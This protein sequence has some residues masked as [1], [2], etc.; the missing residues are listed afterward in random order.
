MGCTIRNYYLSAYNYI[1]SRDY[2]QNYR[3]KDY[4][5]LKTA[6]GFCGAL[7]S[8]SLARP[9]IKGSSLKG[10]N[11]TIIKLISGNPYSAAATPKARKNH[12]SRRLG[13]SKIDDK[14]LSIIANEIIRVRYKRN[15][16]VKPKE[17][18]HGV[19]SEISK[20][21]DD[22]RELIHKLWQKGEKI[23]TSHPI[24]REGLRCYT[25]IKLG[26]DKK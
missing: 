3:L 21:I 25:R 16:I 15:K 24:I 26:K 12:Q 2:E 17:F 18:D 7:D 10:F 19:Y 20:K 8:C 9:A 1:D 5:G 4:M 14:T 11:P 22:A 6:N 23:D 13:L